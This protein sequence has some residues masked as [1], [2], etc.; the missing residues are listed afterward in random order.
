MGRGVGIEVNG[1][2]VRVAVVEG[3]GRGGKLIAFHEQPIDSDPKKPVDEAAAEA[4][5]FALAAVKGKGGRIAGSL[6]SG[7]A[8]VRELTLPFTSEDQIRKTYRFELESQ[9]HNYSIEDLVCDYFT[10]GATDKSST[11]LAAAV[12]RAIVEK[13]LAVFTKAGVDP[14]ALDLD[15]AA[16]F[17]AIS[18]AGAVD[19]DDPFLIVYGTARFTKII[20]VEKRRPRSLRTIRFSLP[21]QQSATA[22]GKSSTGEWKTD[23][24]AR[25]PI[26]VLTDTQF[27]KLGDP[28]HDPRGPLIE[29]LAKEIGRFLLANAGAATPSHILLSGEFESVDAAALLQTATQIPVRSLGI[30]GRIEHSLGS[31]TS[32]TVASRAPVAMGLALKACDVDALGLDFRR[33]EFS[34]AKKFDAI[35]QTALITI[36]LIIVLLGAM[37]L[38]SYFELSD[39]VSAYR[40]G[41]PEKPGM[42]ELHARTYK[43]ATSKDIDDAEQAYTQL[44]AEY[45]DFINKAGGGD[46]PIERSSLELAAQFFRALALLQTDSMKPSGRLEGKELLVQL[47]DIKVEQNTSGGAE[48][49]LLQVHGTIRSVAY[50]EALMKRVRTTEPFSDKSWTVEIP[51]YEPTPGGLQKFSLK[52]ARGKKK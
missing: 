17:N 4:L 26:V 37:A 31:N 34:Y 21:S 7:D 39:T 33:Q 43:L 51:G 47:D 36:E 40:S 13:R 42:M 14:A 10:I 38:N 6:D 12:P 3:G 18:H 24:F 5:K 22:T 9:I 11:I 49:A 48:G 29:I 16:L 46:Y 35:K 20:L 28:S 23:E 1:N 45:K 25:P 2:A 27:E 44:L 52:I 19:T 8:L 32:A 41:D 30:L 15:V 50:A